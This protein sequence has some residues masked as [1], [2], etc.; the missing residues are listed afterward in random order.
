MVIIEELVLAEAQS[1]VLYAFLLSS[2][3]Y[4][5][6]QEIG[7][8]WLKLQNVRLNGSVAGCHFKRDQ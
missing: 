8:C 2:E 3:V 1:L 4:I 6:F 5:H 7:S